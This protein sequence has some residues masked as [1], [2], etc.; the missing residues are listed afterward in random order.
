[1]KKIY[2][3]ILLVIAGSYLQAQTWTGTTNTDWNT[4]S[5][6]SPSGVPTSASNVIIPGSVISNNWPVFASNVMINN[7]N[8]QSGSQL[9]FN[10]FT[11][12]ITNSSVN[13][14]YFTGATLNNSNGLTDIVINMNTGGFGFHTFFRSNTINDA[15]ILNLTGTN[16]FMEDDAAP[17]N[18]YN[19][20]ATFNINGAIP[21]YLSYVVPSQ[22]NGNLTINRTVGGASN[23]FAAGSIIN[24]NFSFTNN[25]G[26]R[27]SYGKY[28]DKNR[29][30]RYSKYCMQTSLRLPHLRCTG[31]S[32]KHRW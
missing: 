28:S 14:I 17:A 1:M 30:C 15:I 19:G 29:H 13:Y 7:I 21:L 20:A 27:N 4:A 32:T 5:N 23:L 18:Q 12:D 2:L 24:G 11:L 8:M 10:G 6:W 26:G 31:L 22:F 3:L 9:D 16:Q 25:A